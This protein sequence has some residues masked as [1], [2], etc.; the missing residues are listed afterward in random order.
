[1]TLLSRVYLYKGEN[2]KAF[3]TAEEAIKGA[4][5]NGYALW[6][7]EE[8]PTAWGNDREVGKAG[9]VLFEIVNLTVDS[10]G[11][12][13]MGYLCSSKGYKDL[14][15]TSSF[16]QMLKSDPQDV[17]NKLYVVSSKVAYINK[18]Q[19]QGNENIAD[20]NIPIFRLSET[21]LNAAEAAVKE[22]ITRM[23]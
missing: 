6:T 21:Y 1:M 12:E 7:N 9:E 15:L 22:T 10:P 16:Y 3:T 14:I 13:S 20:A 23:L 2:G 8:Y 19:P 5:A 4:E 11:K 17:R 18:Y